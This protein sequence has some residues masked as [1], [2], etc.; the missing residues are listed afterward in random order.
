MDYKL[1]VFLA[2]D[3]ASPMQTVTSLLEAHP[4]ARQWI[5]DGY[6]ILRMKN[7]YCYSATMYISHHICISRQIG[8]FQIC[9][10]RH[11]CPAKS[12]LRVLKAVKCQDRFWDED[13]GQSQPE[14]DCGFPGIDF[15]KT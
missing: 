5:N 6:N 10:D 14:G 7:G 8:H 15:Q 1:V 11:D 2:L 3:S 4:N 13:G 9:C 12:L